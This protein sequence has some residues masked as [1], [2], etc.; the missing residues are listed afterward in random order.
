MAIRVDAEVGQTY[1]VKLEGNPTTGYEWEVAEANPQFLQIIGETEF[2]PN[3]SESGEDL[4]GSGG[5]FT[6]RIE[7][8]NEGET[9]LKL[10][11]RRPFEEG[12]DPLRKFQVRIRVR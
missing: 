4:V 1:F 3:V 2:E 11:Y 10:V 6:F 7:T 8:I 12:A 5:V 9:S